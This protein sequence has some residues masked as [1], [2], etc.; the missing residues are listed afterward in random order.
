[1][2]KKIA[3]I[4]II[5]LFTLLLIYCTTDEST[6]IGPFGNAN[7]YISVA[8]FSAD[9]TLLYSNGDTTIVRIRVLDVDKTPAI[10]LIVD[11]SAQFGS[12]TESDTTDSSGTA[13][14]TFV[15]DDKTGENIIT[16]DTGIKK[17]TLT[18]SVV[19]YQ[20]KYVELFSE[21]P[22]LLADGID[23]TKINAVLKD[24]IGYPMPGVTVRF[25]TTLGT[26]TSKIG[27]TDDDGE[28]TT[29]LISGLEDGTALVT[30][31]SYVTS[32]VEVE[33]KKYV[34]YVLELL[35][36]D[37]VLLA[38]G[39]DST[40]IKAIP[41]DVNGNVMPNV[42][43]LFSTTLGTISSE[44]GAFSNATNLI[45]NS[46]NTGRE[47][48]IYLR[49]SSEG[50]EA[51]ITASSYVT[52]EIKVKMEKYVPYELVLTSQ[53]PILKN[54]GESIS[55]I[56]VV[57]KDSL[58]KP[59]PD[60]TVR[61]ST[62]LGTLKSKIAITDLNG[63]ATTELISSL[64]E[65]DATIVATSYITSFIV[66]KFQHEVPSVME[67]SASPS[68]ILADGSSRA[69][70][71][72]KLKNDNGNPM[73][74]VTVQFRTTL[75]TLSAFLTITDSTG[76]ATTELI[77]GTQEG[78]ARVTAS[79]NI[80]KTISVKIVSFIP[81]IIYL[82]SSTNS[83][84]ADGISTTDITATVYNT[85]NELMPGL[86]LDF[87]TTLGSISKSPVLTD[88]EGTAVITLTSTGS[89][90]DKTATVK[91]AVTADTGTSE[92]IN[93]QLR[94]ITSI[95]YIDSAKMSDDGI[96]KAYIRTNL[97]ETT[98]GDN[99]STGTVSFSS[100]VG[101]MVPSLVAIDEQG[102]ALSVFNAGVLPTNQNGIIIT[103]ELSSA[104]VVADSVEFDIP[105]AEILINTIDDEVMGD[106]EGWALVKAT[107]REITG[108]AITETEIAWKTTLGTIIGR[109]K[110]NTSGHTIDTLR[111]ENSVSTNTN[112]TITANYG[113]N[114]SISDIVTFIPPI[115]QNRLIL[116]F[117]PD[118]TGHGIIPCDTD[119]TLALRDVGISAQFVDSG[120]SGIGFQ[121]VDFSVVPNNFASICPFDTTSVNGAAIVM[122]VY[123]PQ[124]AGQI[125]RVWA[126]APDGTRGSIDVI[127][128]KDPEEDDSG[129]G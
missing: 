98:L 51:T 45:S 86:S 77:G 92:D 1:M 111:I 17:H 65:G 126:K 91:A 96:Y 67:L 102:T 106:G 110:T 123:P 20:P 117:E 12:I 37:M 97:L 38:N 73:P 35:S 129:G 128:P 59:M 104:S 9:K 48:T 89:V 19:H 44:P 30:A 3:L 90:S 103:G 32:F 113:D 99:I 72:A 119:T 66:V 115:G 40:A 7:K 4:G 93:I 68:T 28:V 5:I 47:A 112:V 87:S 107:L 116:G 84:L 53:Y 69:T 33:M 94:G 124:N 8:D 118:T 76:I 55:L 80:E 105:G 43:I 58:G 26:L 121:R 15:S 108:K 63:V 31:T 120:S 34:P 11:F 57:V 50:G 127:L 125:V 10:G 79:A 16:A 29:E 60:V 74:D 64:A 49:S 62:T 101:T 78:E 54:D 41:R 75:G 88:Q 24:S 21:N 27:V 70:I 109:S 82:Q 71:T 52:S 61:F 2:I 114:I 83:I 14:A 42:P 81:T 100:P 46:G 13:L 23:K 18:L 95:T 25:N 39:K 6:I 85:S 36:E 22:V 56:T 122:M